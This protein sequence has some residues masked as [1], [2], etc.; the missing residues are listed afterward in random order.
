MRIAVAS[1]GL[2][3]VARGIEAWAVGMARGLARGKA[4]SENLKA[5]GRN[6]FRAVMLFGAAGTNGIVGSASVGLDVIELPCLQRGEPLVRAWIKLAPGFTWRWGW[7]APYSIE[8]R[9]FARHLI[10]YLKS[11]EYDLVHTQDPVL[12][13]ELEKARKR[14]VI[15]TPVI[16]AHGTDDT[17]ESLKDITFLQHLCLEYR[18]EFEEYYE[19][20]RLTK[21]SKGNEGGVK[22]KSWVIPNFIDIDKFRPRTNNSM[23]NNCRESLGIPSDSLVIGCSSALQF[24]HKRLDFLI[25]EIASIS[26]SSPTQ[27][28]IYL[29]L[30]GAVTDETPRVESL[31]QE[32]LGDRCKMLK[33]VPLDEMPDFYRALDIY[34]HP[35]YDEF[36]GVSILEALATGLPVV[37]HPSPSLGEQVFAEK[38]LDVDVLAG[39]VAVDMKREGAV[40]EFLEELNHGDAEAWI[41]KVGEQARARAEKL[42]SWSAV[43]P[44]FVAMYR[45]VMQ[46]ERKK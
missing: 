6:A 14:G 45:E 18:G 16:L 41:K 28:D 42:F 31:A 36:Y 34:V 40:K 7:K 29:L 10:R 35:A 23:T 22:R 4:E 27:C 17:P 21:G 38:Y 3:H 33:N 12:A 32:L 2:G 26:M 20:E 46:M 25:K 24:H 19:R 1:T 5:E 39:G 43:E 13:I 15:S 9:S 44:R 37:A 11:G 8:Q 30:A